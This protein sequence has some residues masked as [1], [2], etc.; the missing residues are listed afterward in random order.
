MRSDIAITL[1]NNKTMKK[2][3]KEELQKMELKPTKR[4]TLARTYILRMQPGD[5][6]LIERHEWT[7]KK[8]KPSVIANE[9]AKRKR[10][11]LTCNELTDGTGWVIERLK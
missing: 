5:I 8:H 9:I 11:K 4:Q 2:I 6:I 3:T 7:W 10:W 1:F